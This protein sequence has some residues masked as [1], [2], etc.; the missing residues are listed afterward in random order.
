MRIVIVCIVTLLF[1]TLVVGCAPSLTL[2]PTATAVPPTA[3]PVPATSTPIP[4]TATATL[5]PTQTPLPTATNTPATE[6]TVIFT[7]D[8][9]ARC[10]LPRS[11]N[12]DRT[13][14]CENGE[15]V[16]LNK[17]ANTVWWV[18]YGDSYDDSVIQVDARVIAGGKYLDSGL[19]FGVSRNGDSFFRYTVL[20]SGLYSVMYYA[21]EKWTELIPYTPS[22]DVNP[23]IASNQLKVITQG[24]Q[25]AFYVNGKFLNRITNPNLGSGKVGLL[26]DNGEANGKVAFDNL[27]VSKINR[28][29]IL[30]A[31][32]PIA[33]PPTS[34]LP[35]P[36]GPSCA[37]T[38]P[39]MAG[40]LWI[41]QFDGEATVTIVDHEY[42]VPGKSTMLI[43]IPAGKK[44]VIDAFIPGIGRLRPAPGPF[45]WD[46]GYCEV[47]SPGRAAN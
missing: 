1:A 34:T 46:A 28:P 45:T 17:T 41:N 13:L 24:D 33:P 36:A 30:P 42:H 8:F 14:G 18:Y 43:P 47:W 35:K 16:M 27:T 21:G 20:P 4:P 26:I 7:D 37:D 25:L 29:L 6:T 2:V 44:F 9:G 38:P 11:D 39:G 32:K 31:S 10:N 5:L 40:L 15:Y 12:A 3:T 19:I 23:G 22:S